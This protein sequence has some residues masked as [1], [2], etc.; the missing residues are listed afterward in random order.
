MSHVTEV[1][2]VPALAVS[3]AVAL[4][5]VGWQ[6]HVILNSIYSPD[7]SRRNQVVFNKTR[8]H[9]TIYKDA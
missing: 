4:A 2:D 7:S 9:F 1:S 5:M 8:H 3:L 6:S